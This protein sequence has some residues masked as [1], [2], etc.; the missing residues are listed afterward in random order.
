M[1]VEFE[2]IGHYIRYLRETN[3]WTQGELAEKIGISLARISDY[4]TGR[5]KP[6]VPTIKKLGV[7]L[8]THNAITLIM[9]RLSDVIE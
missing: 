5:S 2:N 8:N 7:A 3:G 4:E 6:D 9:L 1:K